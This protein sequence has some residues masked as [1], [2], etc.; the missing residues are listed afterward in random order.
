MGS[1]THAGA[2]KVNTALSMQ[3]SRSSRLC[4][5][6]SDFI[7]SSPDSYSLLSKSPCVLSLQTISFLCLLDCPEILRSL[8]KLEKIKSPYR[9]PTFSGSGHTRKQINSFDAVIHMQERPASKAVLCWMQLTLHAARPTP[10]GASRLVEAMPVWSVKTRRAP[11]R[12]CRDARIYDHITTA[13]HDM[14]TPPYIGHHRSVHHQ[15]SIINQFRDF[16]LSSLNSSN[17]LNRFN[18]Q[19]NIQSV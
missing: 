18:W 4:R 7:T 19:F 15:S 1:A 13:M 3:N 11:S 9:P 10:H 2:R 17:Q 14:N 16:L 5:C 12:H 8:S 6:F